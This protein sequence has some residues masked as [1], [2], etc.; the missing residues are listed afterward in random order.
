VKKYV[1]LH[2]GDPYSRSEI[3]TNQHK[4]T[5]EVNETDQE[6]DYDCTPPGTFKE[7]VGKGHVPKHNKE[8]DPVLASEGCDLQE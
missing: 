2:N 5:R 6:A 1:R 3:L 4:S 8:C 7:D